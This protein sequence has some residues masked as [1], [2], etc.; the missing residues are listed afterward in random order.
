MDELRCTLEFREDESRKSPGHLFGTILN[1]EERAQDR[2]EL[3]EKG[4]LTWPADGVVLNRQHVRGAP[5]MRIVPEVRGNAVVV[6]VALPNTQMGRDTAAEVRAG[7]FKNL[8]V[9]FRAI[10]QSYQNGVRRI[11]EAV[12]G[13]V[14]LVDAGSYA[15]SRVEVRAKR[16]RI[17]L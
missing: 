3:F 17:W 5:I 4:A 13:G 7:L 8:S 1:Y 2:G 16:R 9:E 12:L 10:K 15:G 6:D 11:A 14:G